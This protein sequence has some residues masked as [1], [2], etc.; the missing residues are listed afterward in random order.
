MSEFITFGLKGEYADVVDENDVP[1][2][3]VADMG[4]IHQSGLRHRDVHL[5]LTDG[6]NVLQQRRGLETKIMPGAWD[7]TAG[8]VDAGE[9]YVDAIARETAEE[10]GLDLPK[11]RFISIGKLATEAHYPGWQHPHNIIG[12][13]FVVIERSLEIADLEL[14]PGDVLGARWYPINQLESDIAHP[15]TAR[16]HAPHPKELYEIGI[17]GMR[18]VIAES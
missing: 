14:E 13:N 9:S 11:E 15:E 7:L 10:L 6:E 12:D 3:Q 17:A 16:L 2:G 4:V 5:W 18:R 1:T 8:H